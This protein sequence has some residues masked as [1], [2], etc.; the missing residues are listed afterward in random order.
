MNPATRD[1]ARV[2]G[3]RGLPTR[4][5]GVDFCRHENSKEGTRD[6]G[7]GTGENAEHPVWCFAWGEF[8]VTANVRFPVRDP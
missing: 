2:R 8:D 4:G 3:Q 6:W 7:L 5:N 1:L